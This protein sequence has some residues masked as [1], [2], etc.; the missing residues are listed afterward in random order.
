M[1]ESYIAQPHPLRQ[2]ATADSKTPDNIVPITP[3]REPDRAA[4]PPRQPPYD[5]G[6]EQALLGAL[7]LTNGAAYEQVADFLEPDHFGHAVHGRIFAAIG[8]LVERGESANPVT[9]RGVCDQDPALAAVGGARYLVDLVRSTITVVNT[10]DYGRHIR[11]LYLRRQLVALGEEVTNDAYRQDLDDPAAAQI[12]RAEAKLY[13]IATRGLAEGGL[14]IIDPA[15]ARAV[16]TAK[17]A[18]KRGRRTV[19][20]ATGL[21]D[22]DEKLGGLNK[23][24]LVI[25]AGRPSMGKTALAIN[26]AFNAAYRDPPERATVG[27]F[28]LEM[29]AEQLATRIIGDITHVGAD[30]MRRGAVSDEDI[31]RFPGLQRHL[32]GRLT[33]W[34]DDT[35]ALSAAQVRTRARRLKRRQ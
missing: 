8:K 1:S 28:S 3:L 16:D 25:L 27:F 35:P 2:P 11:D 10:P 29:S 4:Q 12:E 15:I 33:L 7:L 30:R 17:A 20:V 19:G 31:E 9:L 24:D 13:G 18:H 23:S 32:A 6:V 26:I 14:A 22:L 21:V 5:V 34:I